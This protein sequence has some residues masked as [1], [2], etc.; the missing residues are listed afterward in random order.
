MWT[1]PAWA[2]VDLAVPGKLR[3]RSL[4]VEVDGRHK[5]AARRLIDALARRY[6]DRTWFVTAHCPNE[7]EGPMRALGFLRRPDDI[8]QRHMRLT[9]GGG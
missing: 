4:V 9:L 6:P 8:A 7:L 5:G 3:L 1:C 2:A